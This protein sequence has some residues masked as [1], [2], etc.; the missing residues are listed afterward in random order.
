MPTIILGL[1]SQQHLFGLQDPCYKEQLE[2]CLVFSPVL[3]G[4][5]QMV[6]Q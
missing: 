2:K 4:V 3:C 5:E 1:V 6:C